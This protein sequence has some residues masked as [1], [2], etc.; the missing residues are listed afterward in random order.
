ME[1][2]IQRDARASSSTPSTAT[3]A[4]RPRP[5]LAFPLPA[6]D[7]L[8]LHRRARRG[9]RPAQ[10]VVRRT[11]PRS[12]GAGPPRSEQLEIATNMAAY[13]RYLRELVT[14]RPTDRAR[15]PHERAARHT[16][17]TRTAL[18]PD[19]IASILFSLS[20]AGHETT[21]NLIGNTSAP[22]ARGPGALGRVVADPRF[23]PAPSRRRCATTARCRLAAAYDAP[24]DPRRRRP[25]RGG[26][27]ASCGWPPPAATRKC[28]PTPTPSTSTRRTP[29]TTSRSARASTSASGRLGKLEP[30]VALEELTRRFPRLRLVEDQPP[31]RFH[32]NISFRGPL[33][34]WVRADE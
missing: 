23:I 18:T 20:F 1:P 33:K 34:M 11:A 19:E 28:S 9:H 16:T 6:L 30:K 17:R 8:H 29:G 21:T 15:R 3:R 4:V 22:P 27:A 32:P 10:G 12:P 7:D 2:R 25:A 5:A 31:L 13:R 24:D 14:P 26:E